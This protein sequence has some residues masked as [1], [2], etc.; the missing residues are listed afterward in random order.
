MN[1]RARTFIVAA[2]LAAL[3]QPFDA[4]AQIA[5]QPTPQPTVTAENTPWYLAGEPITFAGNIYYPAGPQVF[6]NRFE[7]IRSGFYEGVPLY[8]RTTFEPF[9]VVFVPVGG[10]LMQPYERRRAGDVAGTAGSTTPSFPV[11]TPAEQDTDRSPGMLPQAAAPPT[12]VATSIGD[13]S[14]EL[15][16]VTPGTNQGVRAPAP[17]P[18]GTAGRDVTMSP[19]SPR[20]PAG[21]LRTARRPEGI[22]GVFI[23]YDGRRW[24]SSGPAVEL[25]SARF[26]Q[27][28]EYEGFPVYAEPGKDGT[29]YVAA[30]AGTGGLLAPYSLRR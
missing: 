1:G 14:R 27:V 28:G 20:G 19:S 9:S 18:V 25:S 29:I 24:F 8:T 3:L 26:T 5:V 16:D 23:N 12:R 6:F 22:N 7:M 13:T 11:V 10:G 17:A 15:T 21:P 2:A 30:T 4:P